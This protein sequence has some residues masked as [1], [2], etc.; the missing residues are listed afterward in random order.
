MGEL[1]GRRHRHR[2]PRITPNPYPYGNLVWK[3]AG[4]DWWTTI[5]RK[6]VGCLSETQPTTYGQLR[7]KPHTFLNKRIPEVLKPT[8]YVHQHETKID[9]R[10]ICSPAEGERGQQDGQ[11][12]RVGG[13]HGRLARADR[14]DGH[15]CL[16]GKTTRSRVFWSMVS[17][18]PGWFWKQ[19]WSWHW[20]TP[21]GRGNGEA[22]ILLWLFVR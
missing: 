17:T 11:A 5:K 4:P 19:L 7:R 14:M 3:V 10:F 22:V 6:R 9:Q 20:G 13:K 21:N 16:K 18:L 1:S 8:T 12:G 2:R 15:S